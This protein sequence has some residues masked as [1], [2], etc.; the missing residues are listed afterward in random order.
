MSSSSGG[1]KG[2]IEETKQELAKCH[3]PSREE[4]MSSTWVVIVSVILLA[5]YVGLSDF[6]L[7]KVVNFL[8]SK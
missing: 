4:L 3:W 5:A 1:V 2:F 6:G 7:S 8:T